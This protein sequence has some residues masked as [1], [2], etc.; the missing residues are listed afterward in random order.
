MLG[1]R[2]HIS[3]S[4]ID[5]LAN[6]LI[7]KLLLRTVHR[8]LHHTSPKLATMAGLLT[9]RYDESMTLGQGFDS[10]LQEPRAIE[11]VQ[12]GW[13]TPAVQICPEATS[14]VVTYFSHFVDK[15]SDVARLLNISAA[16][17]IK[18]G[19]IENLLGLDE[20]KFATSDFNVLVSVKVVNRE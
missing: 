17:Y 10:F 6:D 5:L 14:Q 13:I 15:L 4:T 1:A 20:A 8:R 9:A 19:S 7:F 18:N 3:I 11:A 2:L 12:F 16:A